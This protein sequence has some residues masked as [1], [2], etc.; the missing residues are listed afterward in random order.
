MLSNKQKITTTMRSKKK[1]QRQSKKNIYVNHKK[2]QSVSYLQ[3]QNYT[4]TLVDPTFRFMFVNIY[5]VAHTNSH[6]K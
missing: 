3:N 6:T 4:Q 5:S 1:K 2:K